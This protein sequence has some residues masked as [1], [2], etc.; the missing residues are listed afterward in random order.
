MSCKWRASRLGLG[1]VALAFQSWVAWKGTCRLF[2][3]S[4]TADVSQFPSQKLGE[5][6]M[7]WNIRLARG[8]AL[9]VHPQRALLG[10]CAVASGTIFLA[11]A[12]TR[13]RCANA[14]P[15]VQKG[16]VQK[17][18]EH[19]RWPGIEKNW[20]VLLAWGALGLTLYSALAYVRV[21][22]QY[23][24]HTAITSMFVR[25][26][27][28]RSFCVLGVHLTVYQFM[29]FV[30]TVISASLVHFVSEKVYKDVPHF[31][32]KQRAKD[33]RAMFETQERPRYYWNHFR[34]SFLVTVPIF[35]KELFLGESALTCHPVALAP[36]LAISNLNVS[37]P[38][39]AY[40]LLVVMVQGTLLMSDVFYG[41]LHR[42]QHGIK[43][44]HRYCRHDYHHKWRFPSASCGPWLAPVDLFLSLTVTFALP[45]SFALHFARSYCLIDSTNFRYFGELLTLYIHEMNHFDHCGKPVPLWSGSSLCPPLGYALGLHESIP[46]HEAHHNQ[47][48][49]GFGL[50][51]VADRV[52]GTA[53]YP[54]GHPKH[55]RELMST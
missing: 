27:F 48:N 4:W 7:G 42:M 23:L 11:A 17:P 5:P 29:F 54:P 21:Q 1:V 2:L 20:A 39:M 9:G 47:S 12:R 26:S 18:W 14:Q 38:W 46:L 45:V 49:C 19:A 31:N 15:D 35:I 36:P 40:I 55:Q 3:A 50:L 6:H 10:T 13:V 43:R 53:V 33:H 51:G 16:L 37:S 22:A 34:N 28:L 41:I 32:Q 52:M 8:E 44:L 24:A 25:E 30:N